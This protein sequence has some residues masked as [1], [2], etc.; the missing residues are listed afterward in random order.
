MKKLTLLT[1]SL[2][3]LMAASL[4]TA[5]EP[6]KAD[7]K[8]RFEK[9]SFGPSVSF[10]LPHPVSYGLNVQYGKLAGFGVEFGSY[11][12]KSSD[13]EVEM[14]HL[15]LRGQWHPFSGSFFLGA[16][17]GDQNIAL[18]SEQSIKVG[19]LAI[20]TEISLDVKTTYLTPHLGWMA[21]WNSGLLLGFE[22][23]YQAALSSSA[24]RINVS[25][26]SPQATAAAKATTEYQKAEA[27]VLDQAKKLGDQGLPYVT[28]LKA[29]WMF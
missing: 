7:P 8:P 13:V 20:P 10:G 17:Y 14:R 19:T 11:S 3:S 18:K 15:D 29:G 5:A 6:K 25:G 28:F 23:G 2:A 21:I 16:A 22:L 12:N 4:A 24:D 9:F 1:I 27:D 26:P